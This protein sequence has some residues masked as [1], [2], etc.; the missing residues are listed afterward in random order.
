MF[1]VSLLVKSCLEKH[2]GNLYPNEEETFNKT[3]EELT[4]NSNYLSSDPRE[5]KILIGMTLA[6][7]TGLLQVCSVIFIPI[8]LFFIL[9]YDTLKIVFAI[10]HV[11]V[12]TKYLSDAIVS[13]HIKAEEK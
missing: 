4:N 8:F 5:A 12:V 6:L 13:Q 7:F 11:G 10:L 3:I 2:K 1:L 9:I